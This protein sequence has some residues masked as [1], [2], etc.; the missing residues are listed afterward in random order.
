M[1]RN[2]LD[3]EIERVRGALFR[4]KQ[5]VKSDSDEQEIHL[6]QEEL[7]DLE[8]QKEAGLPREE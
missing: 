6:L 3:E 7:I 2:Y 8:M 5:S 4:A 1:S